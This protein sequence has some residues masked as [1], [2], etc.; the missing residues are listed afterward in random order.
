MNVHIFLLKKVMYVE[1]EA[2]EFLRGDHDSI[3]GRPPHRC[4]DNLQKTANG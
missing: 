1:D 3:V 4:I 2:N